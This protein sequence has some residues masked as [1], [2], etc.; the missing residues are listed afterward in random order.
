MNLT[1]QF[2]FIYLM[3]WVSITVKQFMDLGA[4]L[5]I[6]ITTF[7][8]ARATVQFCPMLSVLFLGLRL[9]AIQLIMVLMLPLFT[10][11]KPEMD[12]DGNVKAQGTGILAKTLVALRYIC[13]AALY[14][15]VITVIYAL[16]VITVETAD[17]SGKVFGIDPPP[18]VTG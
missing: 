8:S 9:R 13:F 1:I 15:G 12:D 3:L 5:D 11:S 14:G 16:F 10:R 6:A 18:S 17:G 2:F 7:D 4:G